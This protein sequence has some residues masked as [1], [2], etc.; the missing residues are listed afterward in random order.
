MDAGGAIRTWSPLTGETTGGLQLSAG[1][2]AP[3]LGATGRRLAL[4]IDGEVKVLDARTWDVEAVLL[5]SAPVTCL[6]LCGGGLVLLAGLTDGRIQI[7]NVDS[8]SLAREVVL[9]A[10]ATAVA[11]T[12]DALLAAVAIDRDGELVVVDVARGVSVGRLAGSGRPAGCVWMAEDGSVV[13]AGG[14][15]WRVRAWELP[16]GSPAAVLEG[17][18][19]PVASIACSPG[20]RLIVSGGRWDRNLLLWDALEGTCLGCWPAESDLVTSTALAVDLGVV[21]AGY[22]S[23]RVRVW[24]LSRPEELDAPTP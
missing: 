23:G 8:G 1:G 22:R 3:I 2:A 19:G 21:V 12:A 14:E 24:N 15:D 4:A 20:G 11:A 16:S 6:A 17:H 10:G 18:A 7:W 13:A 9:P 5:T